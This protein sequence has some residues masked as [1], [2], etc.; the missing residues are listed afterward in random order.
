MS[1]PVLNFSVEDLVYHHVDIS[2]ASRQ[3]GI[4]CVHNSFDRIHQY[5]TGRAM[6]LWNHERFSGLSAYKNA[7]VKTLENAGVSSDHIACLMKKAL[8]AS[9]EENETYE[10]FKQYLIFP[11][12]HELFDDHLQFV[13]ERDPELANTEWDIFQS[14]FETLS[15]K[16][17]E[18]PEFINQRYLLT[19]FDVYLQEELSTT[20][21]EIKD[22]VS[23]ELPEKLDPGEPRELAAVR[24]RHSKFVFLP[25]SDK[26]KIVE[27]LKKTPLFAGGNLAKKFDNTWNEWELI[28]KHATVIV[29][30]YTDK[31]VVCDPL[32]PDQLRF[33]NFDE[34]MERADKLYYYKG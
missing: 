30:T 18:N 20:R 13:L 15:Q 26:N 22:A 24:A 21:R 5:V 9:S 17:K 31:L 28:S 11:E 33:E 2:L 27:V 8:E 10:V 25:K 14:D 3:K 1:V 29:G 32:H 4:E 7:F 23:E 16:Y 12:K 6:P 34:F 19:A